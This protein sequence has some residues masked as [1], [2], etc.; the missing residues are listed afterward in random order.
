MKK[1]TKLEKIAQKVLVGMDV[2]NNPKY[3]FVDPITIILIISITLTLIRVIQECRKNRSLIKDK[4][5]QASVLQKDI[6]DISLRDTWI[7]RLRLQ[8]IIK[9]KLTKD[10]Y[11]VYGLDLQRSLMTVGVNLTEEEAVTLMEAANA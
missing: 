3:G 4:R 1:N 8:R 7:N 9:Q 2:E 10:Q 6:Q 11:K 5:A